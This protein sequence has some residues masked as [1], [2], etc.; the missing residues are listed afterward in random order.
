M[1]NSIKKIVLIMLA[2]VA[3]V[4]V[5]IGVIFAVSKN[6]ARDWDAMESQYGLTEPE[7]TEAPTSA[8]PGYGNEQDKKGKKVNMDDIRS[9]V[10]INKTEEDKEQYR[11]QVDYIDGKLTFTC[12]YQQKDGKAIVCNN[13]P[14]NTSRVEDISNILENYT[15]AGIIRDYREDPDSV[16][17]K[18]ND[19]KTMEVTFKDGDYVNLGFPNGAG[20]A[21]EKYF[22]ELSVWIFSTL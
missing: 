18:P 2:I 10:L 13:E 1:D 5:G 12:W 9:I 14:I 16:S 11:F 19:V 8:V 6:K 3:V 20:S 4:I 21:L 22:K 7:V 15:V 17:I